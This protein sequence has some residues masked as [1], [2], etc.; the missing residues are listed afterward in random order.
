MTTIIIL[1]VILT[2]SVVANAVLIG[3]LVGTRIK[4]RKSNRM[5]DYGRICGHERDI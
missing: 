4:L 2:V 3:V 5:H 1:A